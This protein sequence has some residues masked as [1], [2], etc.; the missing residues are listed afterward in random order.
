MI[1][2]AQCEMD[3]DRLS[4]SGIK[5]VEE[6][7]DTIESANLLAKVIAVIPFFD[8]FLKGQPHEKLTNV[9]TY[10]WEGFARVMTSISKVHRKQIEKIAYNQWLKSQ[11]AEHEFWKCV[12]QAM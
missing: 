4:V 1:N 10:D 9:A 12:Y 7:I 3:P 6:I 11:G 5:A 2:I 8:I